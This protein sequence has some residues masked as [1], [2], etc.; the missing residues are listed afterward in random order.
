M[1][2]SIGES[3]KWVGCIVSKFLEYG[4]NGKQFFTSVGEKPRK[5]C[6]TGMPRRFDDVRWCSICG[7]GDITI[8]YGDDVEA[9]LA[10]NG[11]VGIHLGFSDCAM[12]KNRCANGCDDTGTGGML[13]VGAGRML[14]FGV[15]GMLLIETGVDADAG[16]K[17]QLICAAGKQGVTCV[18]AGIHGMGVIGWFGDRPVGTEAQ[19]TSAAWVTSDG[20]GCGSS[21]HNA[22]NGRKLMDRLNALISSST[23]VESM[24]ARPVYMNS[25]I[26]YKTLYR[27]SLR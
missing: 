7:L 25:M 19:M 10:R 11:V 2:E 21:F 4:V 16:A 23:F 22:A 26:G 9:I 17:L 15:G 18:G 3:F 8:E 6:S 24:C 14:M 27:T 20:I 13:L 5:C 1:T 12:S